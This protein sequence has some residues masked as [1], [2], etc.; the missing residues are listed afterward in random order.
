MEAS[1]GQRICDETD[2]AW[3]LLAPAPEIPV[4]DV[5]PAGLPLPV[6]ATV[7]PSTAVPTGLVVLCAALPAAAELPVALLF[8]L[9]DREFV[10]IVLEEALADEL[11]LVPAG[12]L[13]DGL[14]G[15]PAAPVVV[16]VLCARAGVVRTADRTRAAV[17]MRMAIHRFL[18]RYRRWPVA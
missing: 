2:G 12:V 8:A 16:P 14:E 13:V 10:P 15:G 6:A 11:V 1:A 9:L 18:C 17:R 5:L 3:P 4:L 7:A